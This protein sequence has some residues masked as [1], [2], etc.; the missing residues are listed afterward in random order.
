MDPGGSHLWHHD[1][2]LHPLRAWNRKITLSDKVSLMALRRWV[3]DRKNLRIAF[4]HRIPSVIFLT[5]EVFVSSGR[6]ALRFRLNECG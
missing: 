3:R 6:P 5:L 1:V 2:K 4:D